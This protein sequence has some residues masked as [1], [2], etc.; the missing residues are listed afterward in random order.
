MHPVL[1]QI[2]QITIHTYGVLVAVGVLLGLW[3]ARR[4]APAAGLDRDRVWNLGVYLV[5]AAV[6]GSKLWLLVTDWSYFSQHPREIF[7][8]STLQSAGVFYGGLVAALTVAVLYA[9]R[10]Q[11]PFL[12]LADVYAAPLALGHAIGRLGCFA[13]GCCYGKPTEAPWG[14]TFSN[15]YASELV[16]VP[17]G[18]PLHPTQLYESATAFVIFLLLLFIGRK[19]RFIGQLFAS[20]VMLYGVA[21]GFLETFRG[22]PARVLLLNGR[23]SLMQVVSVGLVALG[24]ILMVRGYRS[25]P[26][27][28]TGRKK[29]R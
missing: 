3:L 2:G 28:K 17:L 26:F 5:L 20:Y 27:E 4:R 9:R 1:F 22:D 14:V 15:P 10:Q 7:S 12:A 11:M 29:L 8:I 13:A 25:A 6:I 19:Q 24:A 18:I 23:I 21:R 16:G